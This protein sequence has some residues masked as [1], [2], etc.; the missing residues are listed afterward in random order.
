MSTLLLNG[1]S[2]TKF[3]FPNRLDK[4]FLKALGCDSVRNIAVNGSS[5]QRS[6]R[7]TIEWI[8]Q[9]GDP[10]FV[11][12]PITFLSRWE[13]AIGD[14]DDIL[15]GT[16]FPINGIELNYKDVNKSVDIDRIKKLLELY[17]G[18][19]PDIRTH[20][21]KG[22]TE[23]IALS[24]FLEKRKINYLMFDMCNN[25][26]KKHLKGY[27]GFEKIKLIEQNK[28]IINL[29]DFCGNKHMWNSMNDQEKQNTDPLSHH[30]AAYQYIFLENYL[31]NY[32]QSQR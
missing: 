7:T 32:L 30:H 5:F 23:I 28:K 29:F 14:K 20:W 11:I 4:I 26:E 9:N 12:V 18:S 6:M 24:S 1:C 21:D 17:Y 22:F 3:W 19:I 25:F 16:W 13:L 27:K 8:A 2:F 10:S 31:I 15:E